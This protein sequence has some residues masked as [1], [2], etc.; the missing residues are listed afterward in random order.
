[1]YPVANLDLDARGRDTLKPIWKSQRLGCCR[2]WV[3]S[4]GARPQ[5]LRDSPN[6]HTVDPPPL[7]SW[8]SNSI[9]LKLT[10]KKQY[11]EKLPYFSNNLRYNNDGTFLD[12]KMGF[13]SFEACERQQF[14]SPWCKKPGK[15]EGP[16]DFSQ[17]TKWNHKSSGFFFPNLNLNKD[18]HEQVNILRMAQLASTSL[19]QPLSPFCVALTSFKNS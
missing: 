12:D 9:L 10:L 2:P 17:T 8:T 1:M 11:R 19:F 14:Y 6:T 13:D 5:G 18:N 15:R 16:C 4:K 7:V 3:W